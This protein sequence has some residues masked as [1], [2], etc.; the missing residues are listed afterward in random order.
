MQ[1][2]SNWQYRGSEANG[3]SVL[4]LYALSKLLI[5]HTQQQ[6]LGGQIVSQLPPKNEATLAGVH[7]SSPQHFTQS[8]LAALTC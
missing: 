3:G 7:L 4:L 8:A 1:V 2:N 6:K 5:R